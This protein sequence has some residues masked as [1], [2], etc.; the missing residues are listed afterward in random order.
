LRCFFFSLVDEAE[1]ACPSEM[2]KCPVDQSSSVERGMRERWNMEVWKMRRVVMVWKEQTHDC[3]TS[4]SCLDSTPNTSP[5]YS[6]C[7][8]REAQPGPP[9]CHTSILH[10]YMA[11]RSH[12]GQD[13]GACI[14]NPGAGCSA[15]E[16]FGLVSPGG[17][18]SSV[19]AWR[20]TA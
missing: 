8:P 14:C 12:A 7:V 17:P 13:P 16:H 10:Q 1:A 3:C 2:K 11:T 4:Q 20:G 19:H 5:L 6:Y 18:W 9:D 15:G